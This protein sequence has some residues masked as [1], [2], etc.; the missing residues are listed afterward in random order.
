MSPAPRKAMA[1]GVTKSP[2]TARTPKLGTVIVGPLACALTPRPP[3]LLATSARLKIIKLTANTQVRL[4]EILLSS[5]GDGS[6]IVDEMTGRRGSSCSRRG[7][8]GG[9][10]DVT[11]TP[12][13]FSQALLGELSPDGPVGEV[14]VVDVDVEALRS[15]SDVFYQLGVRADTAFR[16]AA[17]RGRREG[18]G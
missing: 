5:R 13:E 16:R 3:G 8:V 12:V 1:I 7:H 18:H 15:L 11:P 17:C 9:R 4:M 14:R 2:A 10:A 6:V